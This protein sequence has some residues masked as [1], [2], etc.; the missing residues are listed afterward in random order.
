M[1]RKEGILD[2]VF[3]LYI[4]ESSLRQFLTFHVSETTELKKT[5]IKITVKK[6]FHQGKE[7]FEMHSYILCD[8]HN[9][10]YYLVN[11]LLDIYYRENFNGKSTWMLINEVFIIKHLRR[12]T[13]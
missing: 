3:K 11:V 10:V 4:L 13:L 6:C 2:I 8:K 12:G 9:A 5:F 1:K 7:A